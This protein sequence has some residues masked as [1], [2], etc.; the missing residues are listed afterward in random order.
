MEHR[1][2][3]ILPL[4]WTDGGP[5]E[6]LAH[7]LSD[8]SRCVDVT[9][10]DGSPAALFE[11]HGHAFPQDVRHVRPD[12]QRIRRGGNGKVQGVMTGVALARHERLVIADDDVRYTRNDLA[13]L[14]QLLDGADLVRP[15][16]YFAPL[17][18]HARWDTARTLLNRAFVSDYPGTLAVRRSTLLASGGYSAQAL[19]ENLELIRTVRAAGGVEIRADDLFIRRRP[20]SA[21]HF[22]RQRVRQA[23]DSFAQPRRFAVELGL[24]PAALLL[25]PTAR[26]LAGL[27]LVVVTLAETGRRRHGGAAVFPATSALWAPAWLV[28]RAACSWLALAGRARGGVRYGGGRMPLAAHSEQHLRRTRTA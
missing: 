22:A 2:D 13:R 17:P 5:L 26:Q 8:L 1:A 25:R 28:E 6:E 21:A 11:L 20:C 23:Y 4:R 16:N 3:Y 24:L 18:W 14:L 7:Y 19:F 10:V 27:A 9:V 15:Q 12:P